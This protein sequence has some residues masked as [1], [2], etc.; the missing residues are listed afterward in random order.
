MQE[1]YIIGEIYRLASMPLDELQTRQSDNF[2]ST[3]FD[4]Q[5]VDRYIVGGCKSQL[6][7]QQID[8]IQA[9][10]HLIFQQG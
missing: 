2:V 4:Y 1:Y 5:F 6:I 3:L 8:S 9:K 10:C 7:K